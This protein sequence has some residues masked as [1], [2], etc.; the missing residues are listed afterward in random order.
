MMIQLPGYS[1]TEQIY[2]GTK[3][4]VYRAISDDQKPV[5]IKLMRT[6]AQNYH[7]DSDCT[8]VMLVA[9]Q[10]IFSSR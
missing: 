9:A 6:T 3:T 5:I 7:P 4:L 8:L 1:V 2:V 10:S